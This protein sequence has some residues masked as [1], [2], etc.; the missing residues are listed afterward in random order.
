[1]SK[2]T[3]GWVNSGRP[4]CYFLDVH[5]SANKA[6]VGVIALCCSGFNDSQLKDAIA[7]YDDPLTC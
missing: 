3:W 4:L 2:P 7:I 1:M 6:G 5:E